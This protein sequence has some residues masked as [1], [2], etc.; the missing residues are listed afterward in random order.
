MKKFLSLLVFVLCVALNANAQNGTLST[1]L[2]W[3][4]NNGV[5]TISGSGAIP[6]F[7]SPTSTASS[8]KAPWRSYS[9]NITSVVIGEDVTAVGDYAFYGLQ[10]VTKVTIPSTVVSLGCYSFQA[11]SKLVEVRWNGTQS[12]NI[13]Y[14][15][16]IKTGTNYTLKKRVFVGLTASNI[17]LYCQPSAN[18]SQWSDYGVQITVF[19]GDESLQL[20]WTLCNG[21]LSISGTGNSAFSYF[22]EWD[23]Y[24]ADITSVALDGVA[25]D[26]DE[27]GNYVLSNDGKTLYFSCSNGDAV[28]IPEGI[29]VISAKAFYNLAINS[30][31]IASTVT[32]IGDLAFYGGESLLS[33]EALPV[34]A[35]SLG[36]DVF[37]EFPKINDAG[38]LLISTVTSVSKSSYDSWGNYFYN[39]VTESATSGSF[40]NK[41]GETVSWAY[42]KSNKTLRVEG[43]DIDEFTLDATPWDNWL[44]YAV[45]IVIGDKVASIGA[46]A[47]YGAAATAVEIGSDV[48]E[49]KDLAF[50][51][52]QNGEF[53]FANNVKMEDGAIEESSATLNLVIEEVERNEDGY[54]YYSADD[55]MTDNTNTYNNVTLK[56]KFTKNESGV[57]ILPF[58]YDVNPDNDNFKFYSLDDYDAENAI[59]QFVEV[60]KLKANTPY[61]WRNF[62]STENEITASNVELDATAMNGD[63][64]SVLE[65][66]NWKMHGTY[67]VKKQVATG[68][69]EGDTE[70][71]ESDLWIYNKEGGFDNYYDFCYVDPYRAYFTGPSF[72]SVTDPANLAAA[73]RSIGIEYVDIDGTTSI[74]NVT[75]DNNGG[76]TPSS[77]NGAYYDLSGRRVENPTRGIYIVNGKKVLVK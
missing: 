38:T 26:V 10:K 9:G 15:G 41:A 27:S 73:L 1:G 28:T 39:V 14:Q 42:D 34:W 36:D 76:V 22:D 46:N 7:V 75:I 24:R 23:D 20:N 16:D 43:A 60:V 19:G 63:L 77:S 55:L 57:I 56:R 52:L 40:D 29:E 2:K 8:N 4:V 54:I 51:A 44:D 12:F 74:E 35:P 70:N 59:L 68:Y 13:T 49:I 61:L 32:E 21:E 11:C 58:D 31:V 3:E 64:T 67:K 53:T 37:D 71:P 6:D 62:G 30:L 25:A 33:V 69:D 47:F 72:K 5:L 18:T 17:M 48:T 65:G 50:A 66:A 45:K